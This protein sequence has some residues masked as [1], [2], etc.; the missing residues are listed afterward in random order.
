MIGADPR[1]FMGIGFCLMLLGFFLPL[2]MLMQMIPSTFFLNFFA[3]VSSVL[4]LMLGVIGV[5][6]YVKRRPRK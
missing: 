2:L 5:A 6:G 3:Y 1:L 4:G